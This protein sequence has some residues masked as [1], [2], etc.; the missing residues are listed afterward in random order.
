MFVKSINVRGLEPSIIEE[1]QA[2]AQKNDRSMEGEAR[3][4]IRHWCNENTPERTSINE[5]NKYGIALLQRLNSALAMVNRIPHRALSYSL[6]AEK[7]G[8][9]TPSLVQKWFDGRVIPTFDELAHLASLFGCNV[10]WLQHGI[11]SPYSVHFYHIRRQSPLSFA[12]EF[13]NTTLDGN[14]VFRLHII[15][16]ESS[17]YV[18]IIQEF[19]N[20]N[21]CY[22]YFSSDF[23]LKGDYGSDGL[24]NT[25][26]FVLMLLAFDRLDSKVN[27]KGYTIKDTLATPFFRDC[28][29]HPLLF[30]LEA[31]ESPWN[32]DIIDVN[33]P[34]SYWEG[35]KPLQ[36]KLHNCIN[37]DTLLSK[38]KS[39]IKSPLID[40]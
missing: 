15:L 34:M 30:M 32:E 19:E 29:K 18:Y 13:L 2:L 36:Q 9:S 1:F 20:S 27:I 24:N 38:F 5:E 40:C 11:G 12:K 39:E 31:R 6:I 35:Y 25:A 8:H 37:K 10:R 26:R 23:Y 17:G 33:Y 16:N 22:T 21:I 28:E 14:P 3:V 4:A 7:L